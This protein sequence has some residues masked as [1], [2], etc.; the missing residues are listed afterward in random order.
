[1]EILKN[2]DEKVV[3]T[4]CKIWVFLL[5]TFYVTTRQ[6]KVKEIPLQVAWRAF[7]AFGIS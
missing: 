5:A 3:E 4:V 7:N 1:M 6:P 2:F